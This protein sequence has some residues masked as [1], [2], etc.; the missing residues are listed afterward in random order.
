[1]PVNYGKTLAYPAVTGDI[2]KDFRPVEGIEALTQSLRRRFETDEGTV[3]WARS[4]GFN[5][6]NFILENEPDVQYIK[7]RCE[8]ECRKD[9]RVDRASATVV[10]NRRTRTLRVEIEGDGALGPFELH[11]SVSEIGIELLQ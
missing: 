2:C 7:T 9:E 1:M 11:V 5:L 3:P 10:W 8:A 6:L 4:D